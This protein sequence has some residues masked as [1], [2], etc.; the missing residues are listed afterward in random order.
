M[1]LPEDWSLDESSSSWLQTLWCS[2][3]LCGLCSG[4]VKIRPPA[5]TKIPPPPVVAYQ[6]DCI[7]I[8]PFLAHFVFSSDDVFAPSLAPLIII[9]NIMKV[10]VIGLGFVKAEGVVNSMARHGDRRYVL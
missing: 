4:K 7:Q 1:V 5:K 3:S 9:I 8:V 10:T 6:P 2:L